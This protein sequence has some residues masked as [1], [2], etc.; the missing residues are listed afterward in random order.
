MF[1]QDRDSAHKYG[2][3]SLS[4]QFRLAFDA[5]AAFSS[6]VTRTSI[7]SISIA[8]AAWLNTASAA[9]TRVAGGVVASTM[10]LSNVVAA[11]ADLHEDR[12]GR[13]RAL[14]AGNILRGTVRNPRKVHLGPWQFEHSL[15]V[16]SQQRVL[17]V[18]RRDELSLLLDTRLK[19]VV[20]DIHR[21]GRT[22]TVSLR[23][24]SGGRAVGLPRAGEVIELGPGAPDWLGILR[25]R[26]QMADRLSNPPWTHSEGGIPNCEPQE[27]RPP[28]DLLRVLEGLR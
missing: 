25:T 15:E 4:V 27:E 11:A 3:Q 2:L 1:A 22:T 5:S 26:A 7:S 10:T 21:N 8:L 9:L 16:V 20:T 17:R 24:S 23:L 28:R 18:R 12:L 13:A 19:A 6:S 14:L